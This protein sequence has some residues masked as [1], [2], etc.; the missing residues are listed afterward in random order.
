M[1]GVTAQTKAGLEYAIAE[2]P[3]FEVN[4]AIDAPIFLFPTNGPLLVLDAGHLKIES[5][6]IDRKLRDKNTGNSEE[7]YQQLVGLIYDKFLFSLTS[8]KVF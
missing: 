2:H 3:I 1:Q 4:V 7:S 5:D 6:F 8:L